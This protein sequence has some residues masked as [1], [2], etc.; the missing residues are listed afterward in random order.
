MRRFVFYGK[1]CSV[2]KRVLSWCKANRKWIM[3]V[4]VLGW[5]LV[6]FMFSAQ[7]AAESSNLSG[8]IT[9]RVIEVFVKD[10][11]RMPI[12]Q[13][14][15]ITN[16]VSFVVRKLAHYTEYM[17]LGFLL[18]NLVRT[19]TKAYGRAFLISWCAGTLYAASD[20]FHQMFSDGRS[21]QV[22]DVCIDSV[23]VL[24]GILL[25]LLAFIFYHRAIDKKRK[26]GLS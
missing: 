1:G 21:P 18:T 10:F 2:L 22:F 9:E 6:I 26:K 3:W 14:L 8:G 4:L 11:E 7:T 23:G 25:A 13:R 12:E 24:T 19:Y 15:G 16:H 5:M 20:E 17:I